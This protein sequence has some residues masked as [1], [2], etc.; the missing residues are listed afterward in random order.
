MLCA[1]WRVFGYGLSG[2][3]LGMMLAVWE[4]HGSRFGYLANSLTSFQQAGKL[5]GI[6]LTIWKL[7]KGFGGIFNTWEAPASE[8]KNKRR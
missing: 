1:V 8:E 7:L 5:M 4:T 3:L 6:I 2:K